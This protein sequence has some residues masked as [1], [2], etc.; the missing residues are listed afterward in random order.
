MIQPGQD[1]QLELDDGA[2]AVASAV[3][4]GA[5][6]LE[7]E[8]IQ[9]N[10]NVDPKKIHLTKGSVLIDLT[11]LKTSSPNPPNVQCSIEKFLVKFGLR[12]LA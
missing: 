7:Y 3:A 1:S 4:D 12:S 11:C 10:E 8:M 6:I 9:S 2:A 5:L